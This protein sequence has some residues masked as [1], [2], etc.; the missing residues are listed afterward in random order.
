MTMSPRSDWPISW[1]MLETTM[2]ISPSST[3]SKLVEVGGGRDLRGLASGV[4][5]ARSQSASIAWWRSSAE[6]ARTR[7]SRI[8]SAWWSER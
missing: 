3:S 8:A 5:R 4:P 1:R 7:I 2:A 6:L